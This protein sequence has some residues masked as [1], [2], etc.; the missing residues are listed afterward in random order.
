MKYRGQEVAVHVGS[1]VDAQPCIY[2]NYLIPDGGDSD[3]LDLGDSLPE[4]A[5]IEIAEAIHQQN[6]DFAPPYCRTC[7]AVDGSPHQDDGAVTSIRLGFAL[8]NGRSVNLCQY[9]REG[10]KL[11]REGRKAGA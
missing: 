8:T 1:G 11:I 10:F 7:G 4:H 6:N 2:L 5:V 9:C 3:G